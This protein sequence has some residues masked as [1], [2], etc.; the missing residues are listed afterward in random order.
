MTGI[1]KS[2]GATHAL[3][4]VDIEVR[5]GEVMALVGENGAGKST[6]MKV[7]SG[8]HKA[9]AGGMWLDGEPFVPRDPLDAR[10]Q[11]V[12]M[13]YQ[14]LSLAPHLTVMEN[15]LLGIEPTRG[16][17]VR[18]DAM[19]RQAAAAL[20][21]V[22]IPEVSPDTIVRRLSIA[23]QQLVEIARAVALDCRVLVLDE[24]TSSLTQ[25]DTRCLFDLI[26]RLRAKGLGIVYISHF[27][28]EVKEV[29]DRFTV[30]RDGQT[31]GTGSTA[32]T[33]VDRI[34]Q[35]MVGREVADLYPRSPRTPGEVVLDVN[36]L[37]G[38][39]KPRGASLQVRRG[40]VLGIAGL[41]GAGRTELLRTIFGLDAVRSGRVRVGHYSGLATPGRRWTQ[42]VG[43]VSENRKTEGLALGLS[44]ADNV[45]LPRLEGLGPWR[46][47]L[48][49]R[50]NDAC[51]PWV[52]KIPI[53]CASPA[54]SVQALSG[55]NQQ[56]VA[57]ARLLHADVDLLL[58][59]EPTR[60]ID[61]GSKAAIYRLIDELAVGD[62]ARERMPRA[63]VM[64]SSYLPEL[65][66]VCDRIAVM[67]RGRLSEA[68]PV[69][70]WDEQQVM[71]V[72]TG[73]E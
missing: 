56:K 69:G 21:E 38:L 27:L 58:L 53:K 36:D 24:P 11:G 31:V 22:G 60:G 73:Q 72:A 23:R 35:L 59:D 50:Q 29:S 67:C 65:L 12:A 10:N 14:E 45:T 33:P 25:K 49:S 48:P 26:R 64:V 62:P 20:A 1:R 18:W 30:L 66:G 61:V 19:R 15:I 3:R 37:S 6:L 4:S 8:A 32:E 46:F 63:V 71:F 28:E 34:I 44:I 55:G 43:L 17:L 7:L 51:R 16:P 52:A 57:I 54:Q 9:D 70:Q 39:G 13:I 5:A 68:R 47:V 40:E 42:G 41:I 2:F